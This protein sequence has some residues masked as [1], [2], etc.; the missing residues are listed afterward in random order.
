L[1][2]ALGRCARRGRPLR[3]G[4]FISS[5]AATG[6]HDILPGQSARISFHGDGEILCRAV[7]AE[8]VAGRA[9]ASVKGAR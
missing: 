8:P 6:I 1:A 5:G 4:D 9:G 2:F 7:P 3:G